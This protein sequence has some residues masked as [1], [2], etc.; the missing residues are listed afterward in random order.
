MPTN[1]EKWRISFF[2]VF[3][4]LLVVN[5][6]TYMLVQK[7]L[8]PIVGK[9]ADPKTGCPTNLGLFVHAIVFLLIVRGSMEFKI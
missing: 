5:P 7:I 8:G 9:I 1:I 3:I 6:Y 2:S 4:F